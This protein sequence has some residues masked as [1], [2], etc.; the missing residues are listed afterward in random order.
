VLRFDNAAMLGNGANASAVLGQPDFVQPAF[1][2]RDVTQTKLYTPNQAWE[3][4]SGRL[5]VADLARVVRYDTAANLSNGAAAS[6][7][8]GQPDFTS[9]GHPGTPTASSSHDTWGVTVSGAGRVYVS[10]QGNQRITIYEPDAALTTGADASAVIGQSSLTVFV[11]SITPTQSNV[12]Y[13][14]GM[15]YDAAAD[16]LWVADRGHSR[17]LAFDP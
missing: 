6:G 8:L 17:V 12:Y 15:F 5:W 11:D 4:S 10:H 2:A 1:T 9:S 16:R 3:D 13:P 14:A 7:V